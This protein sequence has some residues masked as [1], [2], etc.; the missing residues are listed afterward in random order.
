LHLVAKKDFNI[1]SYA[2][3]FSIP[4]TPRIES[5]TVYTTD[6]V[7][8]TSSEASG[9][10]MSPDSHYLV[11]WRGFGSNE[12]VH[13]LALPQNTEYAFVPTLALSYYPV[14]RDYSAEFVTGHATA[15]AG[16]VDQIYLMVPNIKKAIPTLL[17]FND[18]NSDNS[19]VG[20]VDDD[21]VLF[22]NDSK[23]GYHAYLGAIASAKAWDL[24]AIG[25]GVG[26][27]NI[28]GMTYTR[29]DLTP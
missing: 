20:P 16:I 23:N 2:L 26:A 5:M 10:S 27:S 4:S 12:A 18:C 8:G 17:P 6:G 3:D 29:F 22:S 11:F 1:V 15:G 7:A 24:G 28:L 13:Y 21:Y 14:V 9:P 25:L 19:D